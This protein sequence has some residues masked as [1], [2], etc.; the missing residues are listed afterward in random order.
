VQVECDTLLERSQG[1]MQVCSRSIP[2]KRSE[3]GVMNSQS[4]RSLNRDGFRTP[5]WE[6]G[7]KCHS[8]V[9]ATE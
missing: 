2:N 7:K 3:Q 5:P 4:P 6:V 9:G 8:D 1:Q